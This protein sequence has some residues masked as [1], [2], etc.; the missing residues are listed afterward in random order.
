MTFGYEYIGDTAK[1]RTN[2]NYAGYPYAENA[3]ASMTTNAIY[4]GVQT[5]VQERLALTAQ[6]RQ[7]W[8]DGDTPTT[9]R[10]GGVY[11]VKEIATHLKLSYG[12][13]FRAPSLFDR[14]GVDTFGYVGNPNLK[15]EQSQGWETGFTTD[16]TGFGRVDFAT[17]GATYFDQRVRDLIAGIYSPIDT[18]INLGSAHVHGVETE[19][20]LRPVYWADLHAAYTFL[21]TTSVGQ[22][23]DEGAQ[24]LRRPQ[25][26]A[27][28]DLT[29]RP[30][31]ALR[32]VTTLIY[33]GADHDY[34]YDNSGNGIGY[35]V[36]QHGLVTNLAVN[37]TVTPQ[38]ELYANG[39]NIFYSKFEPVNGYEIPGPTVLAGVRVKL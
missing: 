11:D 19:V 36:G 24:L 17:V 2:E 22:P 7:D 4:A 23:S 32:I 39:W 27:S 9:W 12:T 37:Y 29:V 21:D 18:E 38:I 31:P 14:Y 30:L 6:I 5:T 34:L 8:V 26:E 16:L 33:T 3:S 35:G 20:T 28:F 25:N 15:P 1:V 13:G 10:L